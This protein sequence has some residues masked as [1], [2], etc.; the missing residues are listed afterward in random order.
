MFINFNAWH[1][2]CF[3]TMNIYFNVY[4]NA[5]QRPNTD[6]CILFGLIAYWDVSAIWKKPHH[7]EKGDYV[8]ERYV[9]RNQRTHFVLSMQGVEK[10]KMAAR[11]MNKSIESDWHCEN[12]VEARYVRTRFIDFSYLLF[13]YLFHVYFSL[14][15]NIFPSILLNACILSTSLL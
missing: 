13:M 9:Q 14:F 7:I 3:L 6:M 2:F 12:R 8:I 15:N 4:H 5:T 1:K 11:T 10:S